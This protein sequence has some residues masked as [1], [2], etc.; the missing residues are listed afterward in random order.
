MIRL[1]RRLRQLLGWRRFNGDLTEEMAFHREMAIRNGDERAFGS[2][3]L[4]ADQA[5]DVWIPA[6]LRDVAADIRFGVRLLWKERAFTAASIVTLALAIGIGN[7]V[8][9]VVN[10]MILRG[11]PVAH[12]DRIVMITD[13]SPAS[14]GTQAAINASYRDVEDW[15]ASTSSF[16]E[17]ALY[18]STM[19]TVGDDSR[20][21]DAIGGS[22]VSANIFRVVEAHP[23]L[24]RDFLPSDE[25]P[26]A[27]PV[28]VLG[29]S[30][31]ASR[32]GSD[33]SIVGKSIR[34]NFKPATVIGVMPPGFRFP[35]ADDLWMTVSAMAV[36]QREK[37]DIRPFHV[38]GRVAAGTSITRAAAELAAVTERLAHEH[39]DTNRTFRASLL[40]FTG[41]AKHPMYMTLLGAVAFVLLIACANITNL[42]LARSDR[43]AHEIAVRTALGASR[44]RVVRQLLIESLL[45]A[46]IAGAVGFTLSIAGV[47]TFA[48]AVSGINFPYWYRDNFTMDGR[49]FGFICSVCLAS[50]FVF[51]LVPALQISRS[52]VHEEI[53]HGARTAARRSYA[54]ANLL[55]VGE[56][57]FALIL[58]VGAGL[59]MRSFL[60]VYR[61]D[62][63]A[64]ASQVMTVSIRPPAG[65]V[66]TADQRLTLFRH[67]EEQLRRNPT[68]S[69]VTFVSSPPFVGAPMWQIELG[70]GRPTAEDPPRRA[71]IV[72]VDRGYFETLGVRLLRGRA[73]TD[74]DGASGHEAAI[75]N[76]QFVALILRNQDPIGQRVCASNPENRSTPP[77][78]APIVG[79][80]PTVRQ[81]FMRDLDPVIYFPL[82]ANPIP[83]MIMVR[84]ADAQ[85][86]TAAVRSDLHALQPDMIVWRFMPLQRWMEQSRWGYRVF[87]AMFSVFAAIALVLSAIGIYAVTAYSVV[88]R[89]REI[90]IR[91]ALGARAA[92]VVAL[93]M[94]R[95]LPALLIGVA[96]GVAGALG[97]GRLM[98]SM[99]VQ[100]S[101]ADTATLTSLAGLL[102]A[103]AITAVMVPALRAARVDPTVAL[104]HE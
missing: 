8:F 16:D 62:A 68:L 90:G 4:A 13:L 32:Y 58:L 56:V 82:R 50:A 38:A 104:R 86:A 11:L 92:G 53:K 97:V 66:A 63:V 43:R 69:A 85:A 88:E 71:S 46:A 34:M 15:R 33:P 64:D 52:N 23:I 99:L 26:G 27:A 54:W 73:F 25:Q 81:Q 51:G 45:L 74:D 72:T 5:R 103:V 67:I 60:A 20:A 17:I 96:L 75:V 39:P 9:T 76:E 49:V 65:K 59:M 21:P 22:F 42:L 80:S 12:P 57:A 101:P 31:W 10:A 1:L 37:R 79:V 2:A 24:G 44:W 3:A 102:G 55:L 91:V 83:G 87:G 28:V 98:R 29:H 18:S 47:R 30:V 77:L 61:A 89:T 14:A 7:T 6:G 35:L 36:L 70:P 78:C 48:Y 93:F 19:F 40:P 95:K 84:S 41:T 100:T 94:R